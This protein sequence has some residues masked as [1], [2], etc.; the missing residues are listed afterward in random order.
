MLCDLFEEE[1][2]SGLCGVA[3]FDRWHWPGFW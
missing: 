2:Y 1:T 3:G